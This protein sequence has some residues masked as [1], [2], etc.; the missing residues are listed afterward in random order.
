MLGKANQKLLRVIPHPHQ[1]LNNRE[2]L[3]SVLCAH[4]IGDA[5]QEILV[6]KI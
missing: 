2:R 6:N 1:M 4:H 3:G 5:E